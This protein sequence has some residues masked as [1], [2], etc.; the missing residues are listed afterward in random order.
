MTFDLSKT[1]DAAFAMQNGRLAAAI[2][3]SDC[4]EFEDRFVVHG[5]K[6]VASLDVHRSGHATGVTLE[7]G[8]RSVHYQL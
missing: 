2:L 3:L 8:A 6:R 5:S 4:Q 7:D 1:I